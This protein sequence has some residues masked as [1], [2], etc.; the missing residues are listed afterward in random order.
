M[1][2]TLEQALQ[3]G[4]E[5]HKAGK[6]HE[7][8]RFYTAILETNPKHPD[9]NHNMGVLAVGL[10][11]VEEALPFFKIALEVSP[12]IAQ[13]WLSYTDALIKLDRMADAKA[14]LA[15]AK[16]KGVQGEGFDQIEM[17]FSSFSSKGS[18]I[19]DLSQE[20]LNSLVNLCT[21][22]HYQEALEEA[23]KL[24]IE[25][26]NSVSLY[27]IIGAA[28]KGL[29]KLDEA[30]ES[31]D[32]ALSINP[33]YTYA[34]IN[35]GIILAEQGHLDEAIASYKKALSIDPNF[36]EAHNNLGNALQDIGKLDEAIVSYTKAISLKSDYA[37]AYYNIGNAFKEQGRLAKTIEAYTTAISLQPDYVKVYN[38]LGIVL[39]HQGKLKES[40]EAYTTAISLQPDYAEVYN[41][42]GINLQHQGK[43]NEAVDAYN[44][45]ISLQP[46]YVAAIE[47]LFSLEIQLP[48][49]LRKKNN[50]TSNPI[51]STSI[52]KKS[53]KFQIL[54][55]IYSFLKA[56][57]SQTRI[58]LTNF[59][60]CI[61]EIGDNLSADDKLFCTSYATFLNRL[62]SK[63]LTDLRVTNSNEAVYHLGESHCLSFAHLKINIRGLRY[64]IA[65][66][67]T[68][69]AKAFHFSKKSDD[70]FKAITKAQFDAIPAG[71]K[72]F[73]SFGEIDC[74]PNEGFVSAACKLK[75]PIDHLISDTVKDYLCWFAEQNL[76]KNNDL[77][78]F[79]VPAPVYSKKYSVEINQKVAKAV[80]LFNILLE[81]NALDFGFNIIDVFKFT[82]GCDGFSNKTFHIDSNHL[83]GD[84][85]CEIEKQIGR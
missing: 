83:S 66:Y 23:V 28:N 71:S 43:L 33:Q 7:A 57:E 21:K 84:A 18:N 62:T 52:L 81:K 53:P 69:G 2:L 1:E 15:Q 6:V 30:I 70:K 27:N 49:V 8:D 37:T 26:P 42:L 38:N 58:H 60:R 73:I 12:S 25:Y 34:F 54:Q 59:N 76:N 17:K 47:H 61:V 48:D 67:I 74:R 5:A 51:K 40:S 41:N 31:Y 10:G 3:K 4:V 44:N 29:G 35:M 46:D 16:S 32:K 80:D 65:P 20:Q 56:R 77:F 82:V 72:L 55:A 63:T 68:F 50:T 14:V 11:K 19:E 85:I 36:A 39:Q 78:F 45:A 24:L 13:Y 22:G 79:N 9:A 64:K 75:R